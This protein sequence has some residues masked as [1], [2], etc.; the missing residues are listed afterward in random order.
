MGGGGTQENIS[1]TINGV[2]MTNPSVTVSMSSSL[3]LSNYN[4]G[5]NVANGS[6]NA[7]LSDVQSAF[8]SLTWGSPILEYSHTVIMGA[9]FVSGFRFDTLTAHLFSFDATEINVPVVSVPEPSVL[10]I[11]GM[12]LMGLALQ[13]R[14][15]KFLI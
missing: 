3:A 2:N 5:G 1:G 4:A 9:G 7:L 13:T 12:G 6:Y 10:V 14:R 15:R 8:P 11:L